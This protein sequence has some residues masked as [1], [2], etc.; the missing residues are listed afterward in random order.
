[1]K[2]FWI[3]IT[4]LHIFSLTIFSLDD[5]TKLRAGDGKIVFEFLKEKTQNYSVNFDEGSGVIFIEFINTKFSGS[6]DNDSFDKSFISKVESVTFENNTDFFISLKPGVNFKKYDLESPHRVVFEF[7]F[8]DITKRKPLVVLDAGHGGKDP[9]GVGNGL[10]EKD[11]ALKVVLMLKD[12]LADDFDIRLTR[13]AD[14]FIPLPDRPKIAN[15]INADLFV[16]VHLNAYYEATNGVEVFYYSR[17]ESKYAQQIATLEN[18]VD[19]K[20]GIKTKVTDLIVN[21]LFYQINQE[22]SAVL[23]TLLV[24]KLVQKTGFNRRPNGGVYGAN[25]AVLRG[26]KMPSVLIELGFITNKKEA[27][28]LN[29][30]FYQ[31][32]M[33]EAIYE[34]L[35]KY[36]SKE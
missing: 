33:V 1:M 22:K 34:S 7:M 6:I 12:E 5:I 16:S 25:F 28:K 3:V 4:F 23:S 20:F 18:S 36:F 2:K 17:N 10:Q 26:S 32:K 21:D 11:I 15:D 29:N 35:K 14:F 13:D 31:E 19:E 24:D 30:Q 27:E 9:G 8:K